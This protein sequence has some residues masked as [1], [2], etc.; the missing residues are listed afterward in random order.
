MGVTVLLEGVGDGGA[1]DRSGRIPRPVQDLSPL[2]YCALV[3]LPGG[4]IGLLL[5]EFLLLVAHGRL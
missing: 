1:E 5:F 3:F 2:V 4:V